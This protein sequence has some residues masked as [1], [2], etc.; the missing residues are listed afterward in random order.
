MS[1][2][3]NKKEDYVVMDVRATELSILR[4]ELNPKTKKLE[5]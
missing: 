1:S 2:A 5:F 3:D 4:A